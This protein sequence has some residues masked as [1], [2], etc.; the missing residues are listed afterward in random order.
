MIYR[1]ITTVLVLSMLAG[2]GSEDTSP[3]GR[4]RQAITEGLA[5]SEHPDVSMLGLTL[6]MT[7]QEFWDRCTELNRQ[8]LITMAGSS[9][10]VSHPMPT[11][12]DQP[13]TLMLQPLFTADKPRRIKS[14]QMDLNYDAWSPWN[15]N[16]QADSLLPR[17]AVYFAT[18]LDTDLIEL[19]HPQHGRTYASVQ[20][21]RLFALWRR[22]GSV[23]RGML[24]DLST[25]SGDPLE[26]VE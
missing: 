12:L 6:G 25:Y 4:Y 18:L 22:D 3:L 13:A 20:G 8:Q 9:N 11:D 5:A 24:T 10:Q 7:D 23:V 26:L 14:L 2:C 17:A 19:D 21:N 15:R 16:A 1:L